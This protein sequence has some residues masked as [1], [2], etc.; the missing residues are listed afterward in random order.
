MGR[1]EEKCGEFKGAN[2]SQKTATGELNFPRESPTGRIFAGSYSEQLAKG[3]IKE[4]ER[5]VGGI[6]REALVGD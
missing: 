5:R 2:S 6:I 4:Q 1:G 3:T